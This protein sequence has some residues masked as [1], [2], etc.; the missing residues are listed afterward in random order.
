M[1]EGGGGATGI[2]FYNSFPKLS[3]RIRFGLCVLHPVLT[4]FRNVLTGFV[5]CIFGNDTLFLLFKN[6]SLLTREIILT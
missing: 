1:F 6:E 4:T 2:V 5:D 3:L